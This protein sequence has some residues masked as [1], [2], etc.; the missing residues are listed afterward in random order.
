MTGKNILVF[1]PHN[2]YEL[3]SGTHRRVYD[4]FTYFKSRGFS[5]DLITLNG[6]T[7]RW[8]KQDLE[9]RDLFD[10]ITVCEWRPSLLERGKI[11]W[12]TRRGRLNNYVFSSLRNTFDEMLKQKKYLFLIVNYVYWADLASGVDDKLTRVIDLHDFITVNEY[13]RRG[14]GRFEFGAMFED[15]IRA[16]SRFDYALSISEEESLCLSPFCPDTKFVRAPISFSPRFQNSAE[17]IYDLLFVGSDNKFNRDG[18]R[19]FMESVYPLL[20]SNIRIAVVGGVCRFLEPRDNIALIPRVRE[21]D[22]LY[23]QSR[24][25]FCPLQG[26]SGLKVKVVEALSF[27]KPVIT[28]SYGL[29]GILQKHNNGCYLADSHEDF[30]AGISKLLDDPHEYEEYK[31][32]AEKFFMKNF[33]PEGCEKSLDS[34]FL[35]AGS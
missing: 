2:F 34:V 17:S 4:L 15:E 35:N 20:P 27:G 33:S 6:F 28:T 14:R 3:S 9:K 23:R 24:L 19:W 21:L 1:Y 16:I 26:G 25:A 7:N 32:K 11:F 10:S 30:A 5:M 18:M 8:G 29:S 22:E 12:S 31:L 13:L